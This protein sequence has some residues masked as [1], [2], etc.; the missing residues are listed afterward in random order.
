M[1]SQK[2]K[3]NWNTIDVNEMC[4]E[5]HVWGGG[6]ENRKNHQSS[7]G[8]AWQIIHVISVTPQIPRLAAHHTASGGGVW[9]LPTDELGTHDH[10]RIWAS[11]V[12][13]D[14]RV[15]GP[16]DLVDWFRSIKSCFPGWHAWHSAHQKAGESWEWMRATAY[17]KK[18]VI[19]VQKEGSEVMATL[20]D[21]LCVFG[22][23]G[24]NKKNEM[25]LH[26]P[27]H[28]N[29]IEMQS[30]KNMVLTPHWCCQKGG[31]TLVHN[32]V[33]DF[34]EHL[35][36]VNV[37][38]ECFSRTTNGR[39]KQ[40]KPVPLCEDESIFKEINV[41]C[42]RQCK[43]IFHFW[44]VHEQIAKTV[45]KPRKKT[46][47]WWKWFQ[48]AQKCQKWRWKS[49]KNFV[50]TVDAGFW[51][52]PNGEHPENMKKS[53]ENQDKG[54]TSLIWLQKQQ[55]EPEPISKR[56]TSS[57]KNAQSLKTL[58]VMKKSKTTSSTHVRRMVPVTMNPSS[59]CHLFMHLRTTEGTKNGWKAKENPLQCRK[60]WTLMTNPIRARSG[61]RHQWHHPTVQTCE[62]M[63]DV[64]KVT[65]ANNNFQVW[66]KTGKEVRV[67]KT[68]GSRRS[69]CS[70]C[71]ADA[72]PSLAKCEE[73]WAIKKGKWKR[74]TSLQMLL[75]QPEE[76]RKLVVDGD[77]KK[78]TKKLWE[79]S[80]K[81]QS[82]FGEGRQKEHSTKNKNWKREKTG[83]C[84]AAAEGRKS[85][86]KRKSKVLRIELELLC[87]EEDGGKEHFVSKIL[88]KWRTKR[89][90]VV[91]LEGHCKKWKLRVENFQNPS[92][93]DLQWQAGV[94]GRMGSENCQQPRKKHKGEKGP[95]KVE[96]P[97]ALLGENGKMAE[98]Q[99]GSRRGVWED[100]KGLERRS[101]ATES[102]KMVSGKRK[103][104]ERA[105]RKSEEKKSKQKE[106]G[107]EC[108]QEWG[109][110]KENTRG[111][112]KWKR[113]CGWI[114]ND[115][116]CEKRDW[117]TFWQSQWSNKTRKLKNSTTRKYSKRVFWS[118][119]GPSSVRKLS[120]K[121]LVP[122]FQA[123]SCLLGG[124]GWQE[125]LLRGA[126]TALAQ[127]PEQGL[128]LNRS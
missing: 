124:G 53:N 54:V 91:W 22:E 69:C 110:G 78:T 103:V 97:K 67:N 101:Q 86:G 98:P 27:R 93:A 19:V 28:R 75:L 7:R 72:N 71:S 51:A 106:K 14:T 83:K 88:T 38:V 89:K 81:E 13:Q 2:Q 120:C 126:T 41:E 52:K 43:E 62:E 108:S 11:T 125:L 12:C 21:V 87:A 99:S 102:M 127:I 70:K 114:A 61:H 33:A 112:V 60:Q 16:T 57:N 1:E 82:T 64:L 46:S 76:K 30:G 25:E 85:E 37:C 50:S 44:W 73:Q 113:D 23:R 105:K 65:K 116:V 111:K 77:Q 96:W 122:V 84:C 104:R 80:L 90:T 4:L 20:N 74:G 5:K 34:W 24:K 45:W 40:E 36:Q 6:D 107:S 26:C 79:D 47:Q 118:K 92:D 117:V 128:N 9:N 100:C 94:R 68:G 56:N 121:A 35:N 17:G 95:K 3:C 49:T 123:Q 32:Q 15:S 55:N 59:D 48:K 109:D 39:G 31:L 29:V 63:K 115:K 18:D 8:S 42:G 10:G 66:T 58:L 119:Q